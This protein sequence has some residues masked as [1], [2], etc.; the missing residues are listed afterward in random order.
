MINYQN[1]ADSNIA[2]IV[3]YKP[4]K[5]TKELER[6]LGMRHSRQPEMY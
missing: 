2:E 1:L 6:E 4:G 3:P 5:P